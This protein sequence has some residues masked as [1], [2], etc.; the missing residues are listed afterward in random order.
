MS[1]FASIS[2]AIADRL[3]ERQVS[4]MV[5][6]VRAAAAPESITTYIGVALGD[7]RQPERAALFGL[8]TWITEVR[9]TLQARPVAGVHRTAMHAVD[10]LF[11]RMLQA[12]RLG[13]SGD[14]FT[15][16]LTALG[17]QGYSGPDGDVGADSFAPASIARDV[18]VVSVPVGVITFSLWVK[19]VTAT[20]TLDPHQT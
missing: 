6:Y 19:H 10:E 11:P 4:A 8:T 3:A 7:S 9:L 12:L 16:R 2:D 20:G 15:D 14:S 5:G 1:V 17:V 13:D 18:E